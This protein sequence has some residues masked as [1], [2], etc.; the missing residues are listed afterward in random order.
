MNRKKHSSNFKAQVALEAIRGEITIAEISQKHNVHPSQI[1][2]WKA[3]ALANMASIFEK[4]M[5]SKASDDKG[6]IALERKVG[7]LTIENDY[8]KKSYTISLKTRGG[9]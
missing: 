5:I 8:L 7:Q 9:K 4:G 2:A 1:Q 6:L 3:E